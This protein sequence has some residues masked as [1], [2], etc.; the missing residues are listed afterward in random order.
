M[1]K[2]ALI[3]GIMLT[4]LGVFQGFRYLFD[5]NTLTQYGKGYVWG[6]MFLLITGLVLI[7]FGLIKKETN[8]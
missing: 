8:P 2:I 1:K 5:Y 6:S 4:L 3:L 7:S